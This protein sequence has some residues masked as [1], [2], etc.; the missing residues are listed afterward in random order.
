MRRKKGAWMGQGDAL[1]RL[2]KDS[3]ETVQNP[4]KFMRSKKSKDIRANF[5]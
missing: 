3:R 2:E 1:R 5:R 4:V